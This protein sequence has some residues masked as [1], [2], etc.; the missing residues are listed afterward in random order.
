MNTLRALLFLSLGLMLL[1]APAAQAQLVVLHKNDSGAGSLRAQVLAAT[2][3]QTITFDSALM[4]ETIALTS[5]PIVIDKALTIAGLGMGDLIIS[6]AEED[7]VFEV[8]QGAANAVIKEL[9]I[10]DGRVE[11]GTRGGAILNEGHLTMEYVVVMNATAGH[12]GGGIYNDGTLNV[13]N[14]I[15]SGNTSDIGGGGLANAGAMTLN[16]VMVMFNEGSEGGGLTQVPSDKMGAGPPSLSMTSTAF[17]ANTGDF[18]GGFFI[19]A[20]SATMHGGS[21][22]GNQ[23]QYSGGGVRNTND[24]T[25]NNVLVRYNSASDKGGGFYQQ[26]EKLTLND[27]TVHGN[28]ATYGGGLYAYLSAEIL[29]ER[30]TFDHNYAAQDGG[31]LNVADSYQVI[32][33]NSTVSGNQ[34][35]QDGGGIANGSKITLQNS[36]VADNTAPNGKGGGLKCGPKTEAWHKCELYSTLVAT[37]TASTSPDLEGMPLT[38]GFNLIGDGDNSVYASYATTDQVGGW[39]YALDPKLHP[40][41]NYGGL[42]ETH[43][44][45]NG[46]PAVDKG[47]CLATG[48]NMDQR[49]LQR[50]IDQ[51]PGTVYFGSDKCDVGAVEQPVNIFGKTAPVAAQ[52]PARDPLRMLAHLGVDAPARRIYAQ[53]FEVLRRGRPA[54]AKPVA[55]PVKAKPVARPVTANPSGI[56]VGPAYPN[57]FNP[58]TTFTLQVG[59]AQPVQ[60]AIYDVTGRRVE[61]LYQGRLAAEAVHRFTF[62]ARG[63]PSGTYFYHVSGPGFSQSRPITLMK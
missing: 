55:Q 25:M 60:V 50:P 42:T 2:A 40:L 54:L 5:G 15:F 31:G 36:T 37:N 29:A 21:V 14:A 39:F 32:L 38:Q 17:W 16:N 35:G 46:S 19:G 13:S 51:S 58:Q 20:G 45:K 1:F 22:V 26:G 18:A 8:R 56:T 28:D 30:T 3:G 59:H 9:T 11:A 62:D 57:P 12:V 24:L 41:G 47:S 48:L 4:G 53:K 34:A 7:R 61:T 33:R 52:D 27:V 63:L 49:M 10:A 6:A 23:A 44:L 43:A